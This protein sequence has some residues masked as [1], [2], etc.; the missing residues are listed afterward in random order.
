M[1]A[2]IG[3]SSQYCTKAVRV[4]ARLKE[5]EWNMSDNEDF[6]LNYDYA[7]WYL[8]SEVESYIRPP[9]VIVL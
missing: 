9:W 1:Q 4:S 3:S 8:Q 7:T 2:D 6:G 5:T